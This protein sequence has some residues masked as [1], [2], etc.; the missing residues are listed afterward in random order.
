MQT[1]YGLFAKR[2]MQ[3]LIDLMNSLKNEQNEYKILNDVNDF[4]NKTPYKSDMQIWGVKDYWATRDEF[5]G[6]DAG[7]CEDYVIA[8]YF[9]LIQLG[10]PEEKLFFTYTKSLKFKTAHMVLTYFKTPK[11]IPL[12]LGNYNKKILPATERKDLKPIA[13]FRGKEIYLAKQRGLGKQ[14]P[15]GKNNTKK[16]NNLILRIRS[17]EK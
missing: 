1:K 2:R 13:N 7:D 3:A 11:S 12:V 5:L 6:K 14:V 8:K 10:I 9:T 4:F 16:W 15:A 17:A